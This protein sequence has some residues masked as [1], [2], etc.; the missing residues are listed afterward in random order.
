L[1]VSGLHGGRSALAVGTRWAAC[2]CSLRGW[3]FK[4]LPFFRHAGVC[5]CERGL[6]GRIAAVVK[7]LGMTV[8]GESAKDRR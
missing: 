3:L 1:P 6:D 4:M 7:A 8:G 2:A 5:R